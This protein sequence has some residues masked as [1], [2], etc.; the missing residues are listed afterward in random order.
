MRIQ[1]LAIVL[2]LAAALGGC[3]QITV[4]RVHPRKPWETR[5]MRYSLPKPFVRVASQMQGPP[6][7]E[8]V[9]LPDE[10]ATY[11]I[12][13]VSVLSAHQYGV[14]FDQRG[15][16]K[17]V[18]FKPASASLAADAATTSGAVAS[19]IIDRQVAEEIKRDADLAAA[20]N[21]VDEAT[22]ARDLAQRKL[23]RL[24]A[25]FGENPADPAQLKQVQEAQNAVD[26]AQKTLDV[27]ERSLDRLRR[28]RTNV[29]VVPGAFATPGPTTLPDVKEKNTA[30]PAKF[31]KESLHLPSGHT[32]VLYAINEGSV[33]G[34]GGRR[35]AA[36]RLDAVGV[37]APHLPA[38]QPAD[39][40]P[41]FET[42]TI[43]PKKR[44]KAG[45]ETGGEGDRILE[46]DLTFTFGA[47]PI[48]QFRRPVSRIDA[49][50]FLLSKAPADQDET[51]V[52]PP[53]AD[54]E[55]E[56]D[57]ESN[58]V[59]L[60]RQLDPGRYKV[61]VWYLEKGASALNAI[62]VF[63]AVAE[64]I[65]EQEAKF[66]AGQPLVFKFR[67]PVSGISDPQ[68]KLAVAPLDGEDTLVDPAL[69]QK[70]VEFGSDAVT[71]TRKLGVGRYKLA[72]VYREE[73]ILPDEDVAIVTFTIE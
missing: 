44:R 71:L 4:K 37:P 33:V 12:D 30:T 39:A 27:K 46:N 15:F 9:Y 73:E 25:Q 66:K 22:A 29:D 65:L 6:K 47:S 36:I 21:A 20:R 11:G 38:T 28:T 13:V 50:Q 3:T 23:D 63:L 62:P 8:V 18:R 49:S 40:Q 56:F 69:E 54:N 26:D 57:S 14:E 2:S 72:M 68:F 42:P 41:E 16:L 64:P 10:D 35:E 31:E 7:V 5:G 19:G 32:P 58:V 59:T 60:N 61:L 51:P 70:E 17:E 55:I 43:T 34:A 48:F 53:L 24:T 45:E 52:E 1:L 67:R